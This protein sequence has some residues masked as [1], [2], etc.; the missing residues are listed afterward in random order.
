MIQI[1]CVTTVFEPEVW[2]NGA[3]PRVLETL[4]AADPLI[5]SNQR[6][7][8]MKATQLELPLDRSTCTAC[9]RGVKVPRRG[10]CR[11]C[12]MDDLTARGPIDGRV[13]RDPLERLLENVDKSG[14]CWLWTGQLNNKGYGL[15]SYRNQKRAAH[16]VLWE[17]LVGLVPAGLELDHLCRITA[18]VNPDHL[19]P[20]T[21]AENMRRMR[22]S[23]RLERAS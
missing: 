12:H 6:G 13:K 3:R 10:M 4:K 20:V 2:D 1:P 14:D 18:C 22:I 5:C 19:E 15:F 7:A 21:H 23:R 16:V 8:A 17:H 9:G 11:R